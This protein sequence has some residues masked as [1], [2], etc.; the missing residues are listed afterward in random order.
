MF[1]RLKTNDPIFAVRDR[2]N[3]AMEDMLSAKKQHYIMDINNP[4]QDPA[5]FSALSHLNQDGSQRFWMEVDCKLE[6][7]E[8]KGK[9]LT[10]V[11]SASKLWPMEHRAGAD[12]HNPSHGQGFPYH[13][14]PDNRCKLPTPPRGHNNNR[15]RHQRYEYFG[16]GCHNSGFTNSRHH[17]YSSTYQQKY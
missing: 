12:Q 8:V 9:S 11:L 14:K 17:W 16:T 10:P 3:H 7:F 5:Y 15:S 13:H 4:M 6:E 2:F 1:N